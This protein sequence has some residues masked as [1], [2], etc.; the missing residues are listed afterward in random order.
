MSIN[1]IDFKKIIKRLESAYQKEIPPETKDEYFIIL[2]RFDRFVLNK[3][4]TQAIRQNRYSKIPSP[5][6]IANNAE[7]FSRNPDDP[8]K[9]DFYCEKCSGMGLLIIRVKKGEEERNV[10]R[11]CSC[12]NGER[13]SRK[14]FPKS[15]ADIADESPKSDGL[16]TYDFE[17][18]EK[19]IGKN[20]G[21]IGVVRKTCSKCGN[22]YYD[23]YHKKTRLDWI[24]EAHLS[25]LKL[26]GECY[27]AEGERRGLWRLT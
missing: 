10:V 16:K 17:E 24:V 11:R 9:R 8:D 13:F 5:G 18:L 27:V 23:E 2:R 26:C 22:F 7:F 14:H 19:E 4:V 21:F 15:I 12:R 6:D 3:A 1:E 25:G 20:L